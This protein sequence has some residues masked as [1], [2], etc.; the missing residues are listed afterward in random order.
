VRKPRV[1]LREPIPIN[2]VHPPAPRRVGQHVDQHRI[3]G[4]FRR[5]LA[6]AVQVFRVRALQH[7]EHRLVEDEMARIAIRRHGFIEVRGV[8]VQIVDRFT[9]RVV[10]ETIAELVQARELR[11]IEAQ[12]LCGRDRCVDEVVAE[13]RDDRPHAVAPA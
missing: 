7:V 11:V 3:V 2:A 4:V 1:R 8:I 6:G 10:V 9:V 5:E 12:G 13:R